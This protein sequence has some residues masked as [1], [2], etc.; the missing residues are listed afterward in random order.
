MNWFHQRVVSIFHSILSRPQRV[1]MEEARILDGKDRSF[2][3]N[4][5]IKQSNSTAMKILLQH[6]TVYWL[7]CNSNL[8]IYYRSMEVT[9]LS[10]CCAFTGKN[11][12]KG[13]F[14]LIR[15]GF[16][17]QSWTLWT[18]L[19]RRLLR[20]YGMVTHVNNLFRFSLSWRRIH[21]SESITLLGECIIE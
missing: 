4:L 18:A 17:P 2:F 5:L 19:G 21:H 10:P 11:G 20:S 12:F 15:E 16:L 13:Y 6:W 14:M 1:W 7:Q 3:S 8:Y 9:F